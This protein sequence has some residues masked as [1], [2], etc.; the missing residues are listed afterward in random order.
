MAFHTL[1]SERQWM[2]QIDYNRSRRASSAAGRQKGPFSRVI[3][4][5]LLKAAGIAEESAD[6]GKQ[7]QPVLMPTA[8]SLPATIGGHPDLFGVVVMVVFISFC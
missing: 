5:I 8:V 4:N 7:R 3:F 2:E 6:G 1:S